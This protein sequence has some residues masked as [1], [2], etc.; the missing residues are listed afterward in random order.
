[1]IEYFWTIV[2]HVWKIAV[3]SK[4]ISRGPLRNFSLIIRLSSMHL[5]LSFFT[6]GRKLTLSLRK[7]L[8]FGR[9]SF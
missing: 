3:N 2:N 6:K 4:I 8:A 9:T 5:Y 7:F 1:M